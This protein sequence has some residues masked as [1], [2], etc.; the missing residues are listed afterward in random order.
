MEKIFTKEMSNLGRQ[1]ELDLAKG[2]AIIFM[3]WVH[4][5]EYIKRKPLKV[6]YIAE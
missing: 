2:L 3:I 6:E 4:V 1:R 5:N